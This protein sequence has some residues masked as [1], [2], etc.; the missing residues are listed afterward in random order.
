M[1][2]ARFIIRGLTGQYDEIK[3]DLEVISKW[4]GFPCV[5]RRNLSFYLI[6]KSTRAN[7]QNPAILPLRKHES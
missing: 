7:P 6:G 3:D 4:S 1:I 2:I 5:N